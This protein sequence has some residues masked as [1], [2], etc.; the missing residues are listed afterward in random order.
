MPKRALEQRLQKLGA[1]IQEA[2]SRLGNRTGFEN[3]NI[4]GVLETINHDLEG[5][6]HDDPVKANARYDA[7][8]A[9]IEAVR[10]RLD[11]A[12]PKG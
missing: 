11:A 3:D 5:V 12:R 4:G 8:E 1:A 9:K 10:S 7:L 2:K 6:T